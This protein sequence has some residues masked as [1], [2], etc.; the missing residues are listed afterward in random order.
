[1]ACSVAHQGA[2]LRNICTFCAC[3][4]E[5]SESECVCAGGGGGVTVRSAVTNSARCL[6]TISSGATAHVTDE[7]SAALDARALSAFVRVRPDGCDAETT[8][9]TIAART[10]ANVEA[11]STA[12]PLLLALLAASPLVV[13]VVVAL[14][15]EASD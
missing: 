7:R 2:P 13:V 11:V 10:M 15:T 12:P 1:V 6:R 5:L 4:C 8:K 14:A 3:V 9:H